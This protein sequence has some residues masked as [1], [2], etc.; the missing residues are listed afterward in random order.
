MQKFLKDPPGYYQTKVSEHIRKTFPDDSAL[1][2]TA[3]E[4]LYSFD[5]S[6]WQGYFTEAVVN[7]SPYLDIKP[8]G[9]AFL[10]EGWEQKLRK[11]FFVYAESDLEAEAVLKLRKLSTQIIEC[12]EL[13]KPQLHFTPEA[14]LWMFGIDPDG[15]NIHPE[16]V[17][18]ARFR[19][20]HQLTRQGGN[21]KSVKK[22]P[23]LK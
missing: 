16:F 21:K 10:A 5:F 9:T 19:L 22:K 23:V 15:I 18:R 3:V 2:F 4:N 6:R 1:N 20:E 8:E 17:K 13:V 11:T 12:F 7:I 14:I